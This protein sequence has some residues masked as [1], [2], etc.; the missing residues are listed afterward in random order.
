MNQQFQK[1]SYARSNLKK[2]L[3]KIL[4]LKVEV[5]YKNNEINKKKGYKKSF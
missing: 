2:S 1:A 4:L 5:I 3:I